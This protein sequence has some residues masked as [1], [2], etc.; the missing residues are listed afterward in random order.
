[1]GGPPLEIRSCIQSKRNVSSLVR[2][3]YYNYPVAE[4]EHERGKVNISRRKKDEA[5][6]PEEFKAELNEYARFVDQE[7]LFSFV[8]FDTI[9]A[10]SQSFSSA[11]T[12]AMSAPLSRF[13]HEPDICF[14]PSGHQLKRNSNRCLLPI[15]R[16]VP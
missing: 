12:V 15:E 11:T 3:P 8:A 1:M 16:H 10:A 7:W 5:P 2:I 4:H 6:S 13:R 9:A 14:S